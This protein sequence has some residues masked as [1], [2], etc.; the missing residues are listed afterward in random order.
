MINVGGLKFM[1]SEVERECLKKEYIKFAKA[2]G[3]ANPITGQYVEL[4]IE[5][6]S[7]AI[8]ARTAKE[9]LLAY[10]KLKLPKYMLPSKIL[11][12]KQTLSHRFKKL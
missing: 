10:L 5:L 3:V 12:T 4:K 7:D 1:P 2:I 9:D 6:S 8:D 11:F